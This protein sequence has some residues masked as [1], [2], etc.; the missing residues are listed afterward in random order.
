MMA[1]CLEH[2]MVSFTGGV[3]RPGCWADLAK[4]CS[5]PKEMTTSEDLGS[6]MTID[7]FVGAS[8]PAWQRSENALG[9]FSGTA[10]VRSQSGASL[11]IRH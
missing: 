1:Y 6:G 7:L 11:A 5:L 4:F 10:G 9:I 3:R 2:S 8:S